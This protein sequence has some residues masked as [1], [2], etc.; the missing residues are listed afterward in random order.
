MLRDVEA[1]GWCWA[2]DRLVFCFFSVWLPP[3]IP[4]MQLFSQRS[5][6]ALILWGAGLIVAFCCLPPLNAAEPLLGDTDVA[7]QPLPSSQGEP[8]ALN[9]FSSPFRVICFLGTECPL[10]KLYGPRLSRLAE[11]GGPRGAPGSLR[12]APELP[13]GAT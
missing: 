6:A 2:A 8:Q 5:Q 13:F 3:E 10:A 7:R 9:D 1:G 11:G 4:R 12:R